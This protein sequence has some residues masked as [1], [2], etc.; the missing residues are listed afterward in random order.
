VPRINWLALKTIGVFFGGL[1]FLLGLLTVVSAWQYGDTLEVGRSNPDVYSPRDQIVI[2]LVLVL[3]GG[4]LA[5]Y[6][7]FQSLS[8]VIRVGRRRLREREGGDE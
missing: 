7:I 3:V 6:P 5:G 1:M 4:G 8:E 2:G